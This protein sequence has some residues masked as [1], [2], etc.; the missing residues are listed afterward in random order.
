MKCPGTHPRWSRSC[1]C[2]TIPFATAQVHAKSPDSSLLPWATQ[3]RVLYHCSPLPPKKRRAKRRAPPCATHR[4]LPGRN[5]GAFLRPWAAPAKLLHILG[6]KETE[7]KSQSPN[8]RIPPRTPGRNK[9]AFF[10]PWA[11]HWRPLPQGIPWPP[12][13]RGNTQ[14]PTLRNPPRVP[15][16]E[17]G[18]ISPCMGYAQE[19]PATRLHT[20]ASKE[21]EGKSQSPNL[22]IPP[23]TPGRNKGAFFRPWAPHWR[24]LPQGIPWPPEKRGNTQSPTLR[25]PPRVPGREQGCRVYFRD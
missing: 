22:R 21:T 3:W 23:R 10:R 24:P 12:E 8:L 18:C 16:R 20:V 6:S 9:G 19:A 13:K 7:G 11:P 25:N 17:Q 5:K 1:L 14:S 4:E 15:G 2:Q